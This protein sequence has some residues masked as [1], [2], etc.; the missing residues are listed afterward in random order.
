MLRHTRE[1]VS[2]YHAQ[3]R[4]E[5]HQSSKMKKSSA[6]DIIYTKSCRSENEVRV[7]FYSILRVKNAKYGLYHKHNIEGARIS[8]IYPRQPPYDGFRNTLSRA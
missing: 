2:G 8:E 6:R 7:S 5:T 3:K 1:K 4:Q